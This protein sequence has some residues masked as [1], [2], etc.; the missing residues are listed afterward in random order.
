MDEN[1]LKGLIEKAQQMASQ[2]QGDLSGTIAKGAAGGGLVTVEVN[3]INQVLAVK[4]DSSV[5]DPSDPTMLEDL[6]RAAVNQAFENLKDKVSDEVRRRAGDT[7][8]G[9]LF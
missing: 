6:V 7:G 1:Q 8:L 5:I 4:I 2:L 3:G 9:G